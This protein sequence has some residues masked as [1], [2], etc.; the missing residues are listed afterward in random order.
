MFNGTVLS[1][2]GAMASTDNDQIYSNLV[3]SMNLN[4]EQRE[5][6]TAKRMDLT[7]E[8]LDVDQR[9][10]RYEVVRRLKDPTQ[11]DLLFLID[12]KKDNVM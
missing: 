8:K 1:T 2:G 6:L 3:Q 12:F 4:K 9:M 11:A 5:S 7:R 10:A